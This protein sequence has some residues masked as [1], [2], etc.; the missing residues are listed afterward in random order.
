[1]ED[2]VETRIVVPDVTDLTELMQQGYYP[3]LTDYA[4]MTGAKRTDFMIADGRVHNYGTVWVRDLASSSA[5]KASTMSFYRD[6]GLLGTADPHSDYIAVMP[7]I[8][9]PEAMGFGLTAPVDGET[10]L[11][12]DD[13]VGYYPRHNGNP[14]M[15]R[16][17]KQIVT[18]NHLAGKGEHLVGHYNSPF[19]H[20]TATQDTYR[21]YHCYHYDQGNYVHVPRIAV[22]KARTLFAPELADGTLCANHDKYGRPQDYFVNCEPIRA[23]RGADGSIQLL[24]QLFAHP[25]H[26]LDAYLNYEFIKDLRR[27]TM[28]VN[29]KVADKLTHVRAVFAAAQAMKGQVCQDCP[30]NQ[31]QNPEI[32][33]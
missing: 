25:R 24:D 26:T 1:M 29:E 19:D 9:N 16:R 30:K 11:T 14:I 4:L 10:F 28:L 27:S 2:L 7:R 3:E 33:R 23:V 12:L 15:S 8:Q 21:R 17:L 20:E 6:H 22:A 13:K 5:T 32:T 18:E 31:D